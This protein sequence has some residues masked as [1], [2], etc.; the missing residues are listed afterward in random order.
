VHVFAVEES[1]R[2]LIGAQ[3]AHLD[4]M[5]GAIIIDGIDTYYS[6]LRGM[7]ERVLVLRD[8]DIEHASS[9][10]RS[11]CK[12]CESS[13]DFCPPNFNVSVLSAKRLLLSLCAMIDLR[14]TPHHRT[15]LVCIAQST[16]HRDACVLWSSPLL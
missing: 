1:K 3:E 2:N 9:E 7:R 15:E 11:L 4:G 8:L 14:R 6:E 12:S 16:R 13:F 10:A 5:S